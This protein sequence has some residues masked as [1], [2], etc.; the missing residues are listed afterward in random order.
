MPVFAPHAL[1]HSA[2]IGATSVEPAPV[3]VSAIALAGI[4]IVAHA[5]SAPMVTAINFFRFKAKP[6]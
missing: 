6:L 2:S 3:I 5:A 4:A 1:A